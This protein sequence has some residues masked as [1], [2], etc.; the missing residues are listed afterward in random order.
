MDEE[1]H[2]HFSEQDGSMLYL[3]SC[4]GDTEISRAKLLTF[5]RYDRRKAIFPHLR[6][7]CSCTFAEEI[8][9]F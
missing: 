4:G 5:T 2:S 3:L 1:E 7:E 8:T 6:G 9:K